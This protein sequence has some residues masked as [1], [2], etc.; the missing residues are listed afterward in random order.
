MIVY[1]HKHPLM[2]ACILGCMLSGRA[3]VPADTLFPPK[4]VADIAA[5]LHNP[6]VAN[7]TEAPLCLDSNVASRVFERDD[8]ERMVADGPDTLAEDAAV[9]GEDA[10][11]IMFTSG[12]T[13]K[14][15]GVV[16]G[17]SAIDH[18]TRHF[19]QLLDARESDVF[20]NRVPFSF[21]MSLF[22]LTCGLGCGATLYSLDTPAE[23]NLSATFDAL[24]ASGA[25]KWTSTP[26][27]LEAC[28]ADPS[29]GP[30]LLPALEL[31]IVAGEVLR[32]QTALRLI[33]RFGNA[34]LFN[35]YGPTEAESVCEIEVTRALAQTCNPLPVGVM[36]PGMRAIIRDPETLED[37]PRGKEGE[38][39][40]AGP[41]VATCYYE[42][43]QRTQA[44]FSTVEMDGQEMRCYK[45]GDKGYLDED[46]RLFCLG[47]YDFQVKLSGY[48]VELGEVEERL[49]ALPDVLQTCVVPVQRNGAVSH[50]CAFVVL[51]DSQADTSF[52]QTR[53]LKE[54]LRETL[55]DYMVPRSFKYLDA[56][57]T[58]VN[59]KVDRAAL[60]EAAGSK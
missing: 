8:L 40:L 7:T 26:S 16:M 29:F 55:P 46:D 41:T 9:S 31:V 28:L 27:F 38:I 2:V 19:A 12:S 10:L 18:F 56:F 37:L 59:G 34:R 52:A 53:H 45:T 54:K 24:A 36:A 35:A 25:T 14:P 32:N 20:F 22:D 5:Q 23:Q 21:D 42:D 44:A 15:K 3:Y 30:D 43:N 6:V 49:C 1:G 60:T 39:Y 50:L 47:R 48:R 11:Y 13:G 4:R 33:D 58:N 17:S 51:A 57:P